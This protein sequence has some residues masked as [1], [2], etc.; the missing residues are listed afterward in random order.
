MKTFLKTQTVQLDGEDITITQLSGLDRYD[1]LDYC[2]DLPKP[3]QPIK[4]PED[5]SELDQETFMAEMEKCLKQWGRVNFVGQS[6]LVAYGY[7]ADGEDLEERHQKIM[8]SMTPDQ[9]KFLHD[10]IAK[11][12]GIPLP[13]PEK[14]T[15]ESQEEPAEPVDPKV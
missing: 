14:E 1:F 15:T 8:S 3:K 2:T 10:E 13:E 4:P 6:R 7:V 12:S 9:V 11:F 5:A